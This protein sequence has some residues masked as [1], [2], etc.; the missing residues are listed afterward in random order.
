[1]TGSVGYRTS[2]KCRELLAETLNNTIYRHIDVR[3][4]WRQLTCF[5]KVGGKDQRSSR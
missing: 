3:I 5:C 1:M 2:L 4:Q